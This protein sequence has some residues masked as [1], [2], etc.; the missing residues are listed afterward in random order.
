MPAAIITPSR[1]RT[2]TPTLKFSQ[3]LVLN[4][5]V[6][7]LFEV[8]SL[9]KLVNELK[10]EH[11]E[12]YDE[13]NVSMFHHVLTGRLFERGELNNQVLLGYDEN[14]FRHTQRLNAHRPRPIRWK[15]FQYLGLLFTEIYLDRY[16]G[17]R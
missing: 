6:L 8:D 10:D 7:G 13:N 1:R 12:T 9:E 14:I 4:Q 15:Y 3:K 5:W 2:R 17:D 11:L 16:F